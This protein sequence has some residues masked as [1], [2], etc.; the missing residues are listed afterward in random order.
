MPLF[1]LSIPLLLVPTLLEPLVAPIR[2]ATPTVSFALHT[3]LVPWLLS[4][5]CS[6][7]LLRALVADMSTWMGR[8]RESEYR[9]GL[10]LHN[11]NA[12]P[13][14]GNVQNHGNG[15]ADAQPVDIA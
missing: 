3:L 10:Q 6:W 13:V 9:V 2:P 11:L 14:V 7:W 5:W 12:N 8:I 15:N 4:M 1:Q